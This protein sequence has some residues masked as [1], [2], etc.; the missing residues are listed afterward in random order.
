MRKFPT[1]VVMSVLTGKLICDFGD[2]H[3]F[4]E[5]LVGGG[6]FTHQFADKSFCDMLVNGILQQREDLFVPSV[7]YGEKINKD[8]YQAMITQ[9][10]QELGTEIELE[11]L[12]IKGTMDQA[13]FDAPFTR[14]LEGKEVIHINP[15][16]E[17]ND[18]H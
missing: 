6:V 2:M 7:S 18:A 5:W 1:K 8:N 9:M 4:C 16:K 15:D 10:E 13:V 14:P 17:E 11:P 12:D 3:E